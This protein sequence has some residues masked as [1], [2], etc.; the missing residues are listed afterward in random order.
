MRMRQPRRFKERKVQED[1][2][3]P[4]LERRTSQEV[5][6]WDLSIRGIPIYLDGREFWIKPK[7][8]VM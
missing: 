3:F 7:S 2:L 4:S 8:W 1:S 6:Y 5:F